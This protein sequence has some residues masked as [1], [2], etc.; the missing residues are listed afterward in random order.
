MAVHGRS[1]PGLHDLGQLVL[2]IAAA[3]VVEQI[4]ELCG[5]IFQATRIIGYI[6]LIWNAKWDYPGGS[7]KI[8]SVMIWP[9]GRIL[10]PAVID[11]TSLRDGAQQRYQ[12]TQL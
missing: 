8:G 11:R 12:C 10:P 2:R 6:Q 9:A 7:S 3:G 5:I 4:D 1:R